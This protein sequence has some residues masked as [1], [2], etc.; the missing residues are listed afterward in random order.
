MVQQGLDRDVVSRSTGP[1]RAAAPPISCYI[2]TLNEA[3][4]IGDVVRAALQV[5]DEVVLID[6]GS[7]DA[8]RAIA[9]AEG[10]RVISQPW[11]GWGRQK[12]IGE[13][14]AI[15]DWV[16]DVDADEV[17]TPEL[18]EEIRT[19]F[20]LGPLY[21]MYKFPIVTSPPFGKPWWNFKRA[22]RIKLYN[23]RH[24]RIPDHAAWDQFD[25]PAGEH[26]GKLRRPLLHYS[27][28]GIEHAVAKWNSRSSA[29]ARDEQ[30]KSYWIIVTRVFFGFP[31]Y[32]FKEYFVRGMIRGGTYGFACACT[33]AFGRWLRD[34][35]MYERHMLGR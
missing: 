7:T 26:V 12:R 10:A 3:R 8:T 24:I 29:G 20:E 33:I 23:K 18:A 1:A 28:T 34:V 22:N 19:I 35:K 21:K 13:E 27:F 15:H 31:V 5:A 14:L 32:F 30:L 4:R 2:R 25:A 6:S 11:L 16:L 17:I 9:E